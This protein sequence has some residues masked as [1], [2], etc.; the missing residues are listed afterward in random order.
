MEE[1][2]LVKY[3]PNLE[4]KENLLKKSEI[5]TVKDIQENNSKI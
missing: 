5:G 3:G 2:A 4:T 1:K